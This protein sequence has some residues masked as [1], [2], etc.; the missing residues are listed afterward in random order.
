MNGAKLARR[1]GRRDKNTDEVTH[2]MGWRRKKN[3]IG[4]TPTDAFGTTALKSRQ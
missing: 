3:S 2:T 1:R 4:G